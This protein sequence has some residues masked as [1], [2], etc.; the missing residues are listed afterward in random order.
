MRWVSPKSKRAVSVQ[1]MLDGPLATEGHI[2]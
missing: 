1:A 2:Y